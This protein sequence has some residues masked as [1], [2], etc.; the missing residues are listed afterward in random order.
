MRYL[1]LILILFLVLFCFRAEAQC[2]GTLGDPIKNETFGSGSSTFGAPLPGG[3]TNYIYT[4]RSTTDGEYTITKTTAGL[5]PGWLQNIVNHTPNDPNG[6]MMVVN[7]SGDLGVF[8]QTIV[9]DLCP[10]TTYEF[11][12]WIINILRDRGIRPNV[13]FSI[14]NNGV[15]ILPVPFSTNDI[16]ENTG[17]IRYATTFVT[18]TNLG[19]ITLKMTNQNPGGNG[20]DLAL[21]DITFSACGPTL[22]PSITGNASTSA[23]L[24]EGNSATFNFKTDVTPGVYSNPRYQWQ[25][26]TGSG[27]TDV[28]NEQTTEITVP[29]VNAVKGVY[30]YRLLVGDGNN[31]NSPNCRIA[32]SPLTVNVN[33][34]PIAVAGNPTP[35]CIGGTIRFNASGGTSYSWTDPNGQIFSSDQNPIIPNATKA[36]EGNYTVLVTTNGC[37]A[38]PK[39]VF[40][41]VLDPV[42]ATTNIQ[43]ASICEGQSIQLEAGGG[44]A[45]LWQ[46]ST[47]LSD[48][49]IS[50]PIAKPTE[51]TTYTVQVSN[52]GCSATEQITI[53]VNKNAGADAGADQK[54]VTG[55]SITLS[56]KASGD[57]VTYYWM[58]SDYLDDATKLNPVATPPK[59][60]TYTLNVVSNLGCTNSS[61]DV[62]IKVYPKVVIPNTFT[63]NGDG[64]NDTWN[65]P[66]AS[67]FPNP[68]IK[69]TN[70][71]GQL[72]YQ[73]TGTFKPWDGKMNGKD[74]PPAVYYYS[75][76]L[77]EDFKTYT[78]W[79]MLMR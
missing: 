33:P 1:H 62:F 60:I 42:I 16:P 68:I 2:N 27:F 50:N 43:T 78:G 13:K 26:N 23:Q 63:P 53:N 61:D 79:V 36:M 49:Q 10:N 12:A 22:I 74:L 70:R 46:P 72:V 41:Q 44:T 38:Q 52:G 25:V 45:Y 59:D 73:S 67:A 75:V 71:Y 77:N 34:F 3:I 65:I 31:I 11:S 17:W 24:C 40:A 39:T 9:T 76:Y 48:P 4:N 35:V 18:P 55:Q 54:I 28:P 51:T 32:G 5:N 69:V 8:Y 30:Q 15:D 19:I 57:N 6:Y 20:N 29:F 64:T 21:D 58:P 66:A 37:T 47:G 14:Q 56:G 7:A